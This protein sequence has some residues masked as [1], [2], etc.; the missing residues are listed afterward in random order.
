MRLEDDLPMRKPGSAIHENLDLNQA[1][2]AQA[3]LEEM[4]VT[5][6]DVLARRSR[7][8]FLDS[9]AALACMNE[10]RFVLQNELRLSDDELDRQEA[11]FRKLV[12]QYSLTGV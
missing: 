4:A 2:I 9:A 6:E 8:L 1:E 12:A 10:V 11:E 5:I 3:V 7:A